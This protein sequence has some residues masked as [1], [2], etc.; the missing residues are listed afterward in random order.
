MVNIKKS[1][2]AGERM[3]GALPRRFT[4][5]ALFVLCYF[6]IH[7]N[8]Q[9]NYWLTEER[10]IFGKYEVAG[11]QFEEAE[12][13]KDVYFTKATWMIAMVLLMVMGMPFRSAIAYSFMLYSLQL[14]ILFPIRTYTILN[15]LLAVGCVIEDVIDRTKAAKAKRLSEEQ[16]SL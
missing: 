5:T 10:D 13:A 9:Y 16:L 12:I 4:M 8:F 6:V 3:F 1:N 7:L 15:L 11:E 2:S 14:I